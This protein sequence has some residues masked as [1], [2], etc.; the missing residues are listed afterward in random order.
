M[1]NNSKKKNKF[2][3]SLSFVFSILTGAIL[4]VLISKN[5]LLGATP[6]SLFI[7]FILLYMAFFLQIIIH[8]A[9]HLIF[10]LLTGYK[11]SSF[12]IKNFIWIKKE[13]KL[14]L[15][16]LS[17]AGPGGQCLML[18]PEVHDNKKIPF[19]LY[20]MGG[21][22]TNTIVSLIF[23]A[24]YYYFSRGT[25]LSFFLFTSSFSGFAIA[26]TNGI[27]MEFGPLSNDGHNALMYGKNQ[28]S[29]HAFYMQLK[30]AGQLANGTRLK[31][32][33]EEWFPTSLPENPKGNKST[34][35]NVFTCNRLMDNLLFDDAKALI[36]KLIKSD[37]LISL[38]KNLLICDKIYCEIISKGQKGSIDAMM[39]KTQKKF[40]KQMKN[41]PSVIR[42]EY[43]YKLLI[44]KDSEAAEKILRKFEKIALSYPYEADIESERELI[45]IAMSAKD[46]TINPPY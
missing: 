8:E 24:L 12:R 42:T 17:I 1:G 19:V 20:N 41:F 18:P 13:D 29:E 9:G 14:K 31:D 35:L 6:P 38:H 23:L 36:D 25:Y 28:A 10:G 32:M 33:P 15:K 43:A 40:M 39:Y 11:F 27:P 22:I 44:K 2:K 16:N 26:L 4:G 5:N 45:Y 30:I 7:S 37:C 46:K 3:K 34:V 21:V